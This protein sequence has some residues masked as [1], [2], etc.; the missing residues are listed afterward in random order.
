MALLPSNFCKK[1]KK[2]GVQ[3][4]ENEHKQIHVTFWLFYKE[5]KTHCYKDIYLYLVLK[6]YTLVHANK[7]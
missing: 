6:T 4:I 7:M 3:Q 5:D 2:A 1:K